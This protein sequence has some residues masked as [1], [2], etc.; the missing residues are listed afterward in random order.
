MDEKLKRIWPDLED[1]R[2]NLITPGVEDGKPVFLIVADE[3]AMQQI[4]FGEVQQVSL[5]WK[6]QRGRKGPGFDLIGTLDLVIDQSG[7]M[8]MTKVSYGDPHYPT[9]AVYDVSTLMLYIADQNGKWVRTITSEDATA[10][11]A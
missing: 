5:K 8:F 1:I 3:L 9:F 11:S 2:S 10:H 4:Q 7:I 6:G